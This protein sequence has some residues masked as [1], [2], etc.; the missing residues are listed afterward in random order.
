MKPSDVLKGL[1]I[2]QEIQD[3]TE[4]VFVLIGHIRKPSLKTISRPEDYWTEL[5]GPTEYLEMANSAL[6]LTRPRHVRNNEGKFTSGSDLRELH[7]IK[8]RDAD[9]EL[10]ALRLN[11]SREELIF[12]PQAYDWEF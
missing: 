6:L 11:F 3:N 4:T 7:F 8:K 9:R 1:N 12:K 10:E 2:L 5:K